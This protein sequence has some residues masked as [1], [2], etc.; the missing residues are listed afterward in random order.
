MSKI[1]LFYGNKYE[2]KW[3]IS[4]IDAEIVVLA[5]LNRAFLKDNLNKLSEP[6]EMSVI[7]R[8]HLSAKW[9]FGV[10]ERSSDLNLVN[11]QSIF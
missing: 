6:W 1:L 3:K 11:K 10:A 7:V 2:K 4:P 8:N 5:N 9:Q